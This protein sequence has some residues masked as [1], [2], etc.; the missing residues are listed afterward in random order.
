MKASD[1]ENSKEDTFHIKRSD[2]PFL[3]GEQT[4]RSR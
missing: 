3:N 1:L 2:V 4:R